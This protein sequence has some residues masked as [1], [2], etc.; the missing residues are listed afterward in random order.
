MKKLGAVFLLALIC[1]VCFVP[2]LK[3]TYAYLDTSSGKAMCVIEKDSGRIL[4]SKNEKTKLPMAS[5]TKVVTA[6]TV[7]ENCDDLNEMITVDNSC[8][9][10]EGTSIYLRRGEQIKVID[11]LYGLMLRSGNDSAVALACH[12]AGSVNEFAKLMNATAVKVGANSSNF[13][14]PHGLHNENHYTTAHDLALIT[15]H[16]LNNPTFK[17]IVSTKTHVIEA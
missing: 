15:A 4:F 2:N 9:G 13:V 1:A 7:L 16:A 3:T 8:I 12:T 5:T 17:E 11:L 10:V 14:N 6:I